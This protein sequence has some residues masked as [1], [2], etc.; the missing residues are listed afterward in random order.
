MMSS[1]QVPNR[2][3]NTDVYPSSFQVFLFLSFIFD[4]C[5]LSIY[6]HRQV[7]HEKF[8]IIEGLMT[9]VQ[10]R[11][12]ANEPPGFLFKLFG[13]IFKIPPSKV[14]SVFHFKGP[15]EGSVV[16]GFCVTAPRRE[17]GI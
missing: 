7:V 13:R 5:S 10:A 15:V 16:H 1:P 9:T 14:L 12:S 4:S 11:A 8:G 6:Y 2:I 3:T 17:Y